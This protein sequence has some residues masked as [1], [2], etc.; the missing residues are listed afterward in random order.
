MVCAH[1]ALPITQYSNLRQCRMGGDQSSSAYVHT[2]PATGPGFTKDEQVGAIHSSGNKG[3]NHSHGKQKQG[4]PM[5]LQD[6][7]NEKS[8]G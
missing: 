8:R 1:M 5:L 6:E 3:T 4:Q 7:L 2:V